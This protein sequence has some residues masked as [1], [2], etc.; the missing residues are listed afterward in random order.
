MARALDR[1]CV[2][3]ARV[4][5]PQRVERAALGRERGAV[6]AADAASRAAGVLRLRDT[7]GVTCNVI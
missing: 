1:V 4:V 6:D 5:E 7:I 2:R 3:G